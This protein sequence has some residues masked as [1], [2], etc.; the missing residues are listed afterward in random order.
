MKAPDLA[1]QTFER[2][3]VVERGPNDPEGRT[4]WVCICQCG[5]KKVVSGKHLRN[6]SVKS[7][8]C[9][10]SDNCG[11]LKFKHGHATKGDTHRMFNIWMDIKK[12]C[13]NPNHHAY[14]R[15]G[16]RGITICD[17]WLSSYTNFYSDMGY[18]HE[19][20]VKIHGEADTCIERVDNNKGYSLDNCTWATRLEQSN[21]RNFVKKFTFNGETLS[22]AECARKTGLAYKTLRDR[23][24]KY[25]WPLEK[26]LTLP[27][28][29]KLNKKEI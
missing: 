2:L 1:G 16:G 28:N 11:K 19:Q 24:V 8:G 26:A 20:H 23:I 14:N 5:N 6:S 9:L 3:K 22:L 15:Y 21:N 18:S 10:R 27:L 29:T 4:T 12:R 13:L 17:S 25:K 7:C